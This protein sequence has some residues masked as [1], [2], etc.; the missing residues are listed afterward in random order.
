MKTLLITGATSGIGEALAI[1]AARRGYQVIGCGRTAEK[2]AQLHQEH[3]IETRC[4]DVNDEQET[5]QALADC[6][7][8]IIVLNAGVCEYVDAHS[9]DPSLFRRVFE[10]NLFGVVNC[11]AGLQHALQPG[12]HLLVVDSMA[13]LLPFTRSQAYGASKAAV[14]YLTQS[15]RV[16]LAAS[17]VKVTSLS[18]GFVK[19]PLT[20]KN[21]FPMPMR[22]STQQA[23]EAILSKIDRDAANRYFPWMFGAIL[24]LLTRL[25]DRLKVALCQSMRSAQ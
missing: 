5:R 21:D 16:D 17:G 24:R 12:T 10:T 18:P 25:P 15:L 13:R 22:I 6:R 20:D 7:P 3:G 4:F 11:L 14:H 19:T 8:D 1:E 23:V 9:I 2:L